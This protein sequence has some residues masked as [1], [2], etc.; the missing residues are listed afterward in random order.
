MTLH[1]NHCRARCRAALLLAAGLLFAAA[2]PAPLEAQPD[3]SPFRVVSYDLEVELAPEL[4]Q[5]NARARLTVSPE[6]SVTSLTL[7][8]NKNCRVEQAL[9]A[10]GKG[11][12]FERL[13]Q[14]DSVTLVLAQPL[15]EG[16]SPA[17]SLVYVCGF[18]PAIK[19]ERGPQLAAIGQTGSFL[20][21]ESR[22][23][24]QT[25]NPWDRFAMTVTATVP[26]GQTVVAVGK[27]DAPQSAGGKSRFVFRADQPTLA[28]ALA[29]G[30]FHKVSASEGAPVT[31]YLRGVRE[32]A[33][34]SNAA[35]LGDIITFFSD[36]FAPLERPEIAVVEVP[37]DTWEAF[38]APG[39]LLLPARQWSESINPRLLARYLARQWW[40][41]R[42]SPARRSDAF[43]AEG[44]SRYSEALYVEHSAGEEGLRR[45]LEDLTIGALVDESAAP[46]ANADR[47]APYS[48]EFNSVVR[49]KGAMTLHML[50]LLLGDDAF[51]RTLH[52][53]ARRF[54]GHGATL[55]EFER[56]AEEVGG[57]PVDY[58]FG[59]W[60]R[61][62]GVP[63]FSL[64]YVVY[65]TREGFRV[66][67]ELKH[68]LEIFRLLVPV[69][70]ETE[71]PPV[72]KVVEAAG[73]STAFSIETFNRPVRI[74]IDPDYDVLKYTPN[75][76]VRVAIARGESLF[77]RGQYFEATREYQQALD[78]K[79][80][81]S[82]AHH[83]MGEAF[84][85]Q[86]NYQAAA[87]SFR[88]AVNGDQEPKWTVVWSH[89]FLGKV[90]DITGQRERAIN[91]YRRA[92]DTNDDTQGAQAEAEKYLNEPYRRETRAVE[93][94]ERQP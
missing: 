53:Y 31:F 37:D 33:A 77:E 26:E 51:F 52:D 6:R 38:G 56:L 5:L 48:P 35:T 82:L 94:I 59:Q 93:T 15:R 13:P 2:T 23:F 91:E 42:V 50:R 55:E 45:V 79:Q 27:A 17:F 62:T 32:S 16:D 75:L 22:W 86:R 80:N 40:S 28:G 66:G 24:P 61:S 88:E 9:D 72:T 71:G 90:F 73:P 19:P 85:A 41:G 54:A 74:E 70:V 81:S 29:A 39:L 44:L 60:V 43:L 67:G 68:D 11:V 92:L 89:I 83:R 64:E 84:F 1:W 20:L 34:R 57:K 8:L 10:A 63:Q 47:I 14:S 7:F 30:N 18:D 12:N 3:R 49:D 4:H 21:P 58:F 69:R 87:N 76:R 36:K 78:V 25:S 46:I 65:R